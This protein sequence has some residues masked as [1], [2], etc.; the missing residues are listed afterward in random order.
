[1]KKWLIFVSS[2]FAATFLLAGCGNKVPNVPG[3]VAEVN[4]QKITDQRYLA[5]LNKRYGKEVLSS[6]IEQEILKQWAEK[7]KVAP[8]PAQLTS[9]EER[10]KRDD[11][12]ADQVKVL[13]E[14]GLKDEIFTQQVRA[15]LAV[16]MYKPTE[17]DLKKLYE[18]AKPNFVHGARKRLA[19]IPGDDKAKLEDA[20]K[21]IKDGKDFDE[22]AVAM[23]PPGAMGAS[24]PIKLWLSDDQKGVPAN[25]IDASK[26]TKLNE[27]SSIIEM[28]SMDPKA[29]TQYLIFKVLAEQPKADLKFADVKN[30]LEEVAAMQK[31][32]MDPG[33][34]EKLNA[35]KKEAKLD[36]KI[37]NLK[38]IA[39][40]FKNPRPAYNPQMMMGP[41]GPRP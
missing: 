16:K 30:E 39:Q 20:L 22:V 18:Q 24:A 25:I 21:Q 10:L 6:L 1:M 38:S 4:G 12:Y 37:E 36:I 11:I 35:K 32:Q 2:A 9:Q 40:D 41:G 13:G 14:Q 34:E 29:P 23:L 5:E 27:V 33:F 3:N 15:N 8:T 7:D 26:K 19:I 28:K 17:A 31:A